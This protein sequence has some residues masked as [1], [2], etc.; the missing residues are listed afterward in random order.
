MQKS[1]GNNG[2]S[3]G[4]G[5]KANYTRLYSDDFLSVPLGIESKYKLPV[6]IF[7]PI[8]IGGSVYYAPRVLSF[9]NAEN[10]L[11]YRLIFDLEVIPNGMLRVGYRSL[12]TNYAVDTGTYK[13]NESF[14][15]GFKF[16]F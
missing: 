11:E 14:Y 1:V 15:G 16:L 2:L 10:F 13:Y 12:D 9:A 6:G 8:Y 3:L 5:I 4:L 7:I